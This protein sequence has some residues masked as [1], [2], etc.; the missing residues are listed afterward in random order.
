V[1]IG[2][3]AFRIVGV[4]GEHVVQP[5]LPGDP[6]RHSQGLGRGGRGVQ[7]LPVGME[8]RE[9]QRHVRSEMF[10]NPAAQR[11]DLVR[12]VVLAGDQKR[13]VIE[14]NLCLMFEVLQRIEHR[15]Q[16]R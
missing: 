15:S 4:A 14:P 10:Q 3:L 1:T 5:Y 8:G 16:P 9:V 13:S 11:F 2:A 7:H 12:R 6:A